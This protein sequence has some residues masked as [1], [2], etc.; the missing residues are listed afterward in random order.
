MAPIATQHHHRSTTKQSQKTFKSRHATKGALKERSKGK[1]EGFEPGSR[2]TPHQQVMSKFDRRNRAKQ[3][4]LNKDHEHAK[5]TN[6][7]AGR[8]A[9]PRITAVIPLCADVSAAAAVRSLNSS[10][11]IEEDVPEA[12]WTRT[13]VDRFKQKVQYLV[14]KRDLLASL[15]ACRVADFIVFVL[16]A[17]EEVDEEGETILK[18]IESQGVS[19]CFTVVQNLDTVEPA[20]RRPQVVSSL[21]SYITHFLPSTERVFSL[22]SRQEAS[23]LVRSL[24][25]TTTKGIHWRDQ[26]SYMFIEDV[27]W[28]GGKSAVNEDGTGEV[29]LTG[30]V[31]GLGLKADRLVQVGDWGDFQVDKIVAAPLETRKKAREDNMMVDSEEENVLEKPSEDQDDLADLAPEETIMEDVTNYAPSMAPT[32]RKGVLLDDHHYFSDGEDEAEPSRPKRLPRGTSK[33]QSAW[34]LDDVSDSGSDLEDF[35]EDDFEDQGKSEAFDPADGLEGMDLD[36]RAPTE[37]GPSEYPQSEMFLD[38][39]PEDEAEQIEAYRK[40]RKTEA[41]EDLEFPDEI[42]LH[43]NVNARERLIRYRGLKSLRTSVWETEEDRPYEPEEWARLLEI[44]DYK[45]AATRIIREAWAGGVKPGTRVSVHIRGVPLKYQEIQSRPIAM[46]SLLRHEH[47]KT[48]CNYSILL[49]SDYEA[50]LKS[51]AELIV[52]CGPRRMIINP[53]FS[54]AGNTPNDV[55]KFDRY[56]HPGRSAIAT[57]IGPLTWGNVPVLYFQRTPPSAEADSNVE[58]SLNEGALNLIATGTS[59]PPSLNRVVAKRIILTGHPLKINK[60][61]VTVRY[62]FFNDDD[63]RW[64]KSLPLWTRR[65]RS[66]FIKESLGTHGYFKATFDG[67]I[68]PMDAVAVSLYKRVWPRT[69]K[70]W[71]PEQM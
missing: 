57:F 53:L 16:S 64:F 50:P 1:I 47:K 27:A 59:L 37:G 22:D 71:T 46:Y 8:D 18:A 21:K 10:L 67:K 32:E 30:V 61:V 12:G 51:K 20:K 62:M 66:G 34:Y 19:N 48:A 36:G 23:N 70:A 11:D 68:N 39:S 44:S 14:V 69:A 56:L 33:Y 4:R 29:V 6:V 45:R 13:T 31:R 3:L 52:Q 63:V 55:H 25:T 40:S 9:A 42:E 26:R 58:P 5:A 35:D 49:S 7:F 2:K 28:L 41:E 17:Q 65:G 54:Q 43:P 24:C 15:D 38:P 60:R